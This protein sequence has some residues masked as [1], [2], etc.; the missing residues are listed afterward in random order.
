M[1]CAAAE[2]Q[3]PSNLRL[4]TSFQSDK[5][6]SILLIYNLLSVICR[7]RQH[8]T[9][10]LSLRRAA[11]SLHLHKMHLEHSTLHGWIKANL[12]IANL[13]LAALYWGFAEL[14]FTLAQL[15]SNVAPI[16]PPSGLAFAAVFIGGARL[17]PAIFFGAL[18]TN[19]ATGIGLTASFTIATG[20]TTEAAI[21]L[22][23]LNAV[24][25][26]KM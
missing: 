14:G 12:F 16:W 26:Y 25:S 3:P 6:I 2:V 23:I 13:L 10:T 24:S 9:L 5:E 22:L 11:P 4:L 1:A 7:P 17:L 18:L 8:Y 21:A 20:N 19:A 15:H